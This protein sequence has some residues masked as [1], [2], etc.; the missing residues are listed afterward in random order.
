MYTCSVLCHAAF[1]NVPFMTWGYQEEHQPSDVP[2]FL[3]GPRYSA[4]QFL[5]SLVGPGWQWYYVILAFI[6]INLFCLVSIGIS[7]FDL[8][9]SPWGNLSFEAPFEPSAPSELG[10]PAAPAQP[11]VEQR[12]DCGLMSNDLAMGRKKE[13]SPEITV[14]FWL[15]NELL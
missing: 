4:M 11:T 8:T 5:K 2:M 15:Y 1:A 7:I 9:L 12:Q 10:A 13:I 3:L 14:L 6:Y